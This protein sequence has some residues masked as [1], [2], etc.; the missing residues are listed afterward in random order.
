MVSSC[1]W[2]AAGGI[3]GLACISAL[4]GAGLALPSYCF[5]S[6]V[7]RSSQQAEYAE[8]LA[9]SM[10]RSVTMDSWSKDQLRKMQCGGNGKLNAFL[11][12]YGVEKSTDIKDKYN[13]RAAEV[14]LLRRWPGT[15]QLG[16]TLHAQLNARLDS[17]ASVP[18][19]SSSERGSGR[20]WRAGTTRHRHP[21]MPTWGRA[22]RGP[23]PL[24]RAACRTPPLPRSSQARKGL[25]TTG[26]TG[27]TGTT[28]HSSR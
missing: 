18:F 4:S 19:A 27:A 5:Q 24:R 11:K 25:L 23:R 22:V 13:S 15:C 16:V 12:Q 1:A 3:A 26:A 6:L 14:G 28:P 21:P 2:S 10:R 7:S 20:R 17:P 8:A 9:L